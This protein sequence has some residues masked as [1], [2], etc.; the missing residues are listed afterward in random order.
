[1]LRMLPTLGTKL[2]VVVMLFYSMLEIHDIVLQ[3]GLPLDNETNSI[4]IDYACSR[5]YKFHVT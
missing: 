1:M 4:V 2:I 3:S 5:P